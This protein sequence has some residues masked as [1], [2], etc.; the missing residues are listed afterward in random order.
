MKLSNV[1][2][3]EITVIAVYVVGCCNCENRLHLSTEDCNVGEVAFKAA[4]QGWHRVETA[5]E[6]TSI[7]CPKC[8]R[9]IKDNEAD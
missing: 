1:E 3:D 8:I 2:I 5:D 9:E 7:A 6:I 4:S